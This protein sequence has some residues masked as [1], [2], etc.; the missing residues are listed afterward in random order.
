MQ[1]R[2][3]IV[4]IISVPLLLLSIS[5]ARTALKQLPARRS[6][7]LMIWLAIAAPVLGVFLWLLTDKLYW[8]MLGL[9]TASIVL[10]SSVYRGLGETS[11]RMKLGM[12]ILSSSFKVL[13]DP[14]SP[15][16]TK[17]LLL[18][19]GFEVIAII[20]MIGL[21]YVL[22]GDVGEYAAIAVA[23]IFVFVVQV[24]ILWLGGPRQSD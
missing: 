5:L 19:V 22:F 14:E 16:T 6:S 11:Q 17:F 2:F 10:V 4:G 20:P 8:L 13:R 9:P 3:I 18:I 24:Q 12:S 21:V 7:A 1:D 15:R 23:V